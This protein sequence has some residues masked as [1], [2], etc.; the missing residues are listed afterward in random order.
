VETIEDDLSSES[1]ISIFK[2]G[3]HTVRN[4]FGK[5]EQAK[6]QDELEKQQKELSRM[7]EELK[8]MQNLLTFDFG[9]GNKFLPF[10]GECFSK[11]IEKYTY[12]IC[13][14]DAASQD[15]TNLGEYKGLGA[16]QKSFRFADGTGCWNGPKR[17]ILINLQCG[18]K[19]DI[20]KVEE[21][22]VCE[23]VASFSTPLVCEEE[24]LESKSKEY[25]LLTGAEFHDEL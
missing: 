23:Y 8:K 24:D 19:N 7:K 17:S 13:P 25:Q 18:V 4:L 12:K 11:V 9:E 16:D 1:F 6:V 22:N 5:S 21:P 15:H 10:Y 3:L 20:L 14:F 2:K